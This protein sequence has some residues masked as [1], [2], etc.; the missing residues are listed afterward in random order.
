MP[1]LKFGSIYSL[2]DSGAS[3]Q[4]IKENSAEFRV[5]DPEPD[6]P[7][8]IG[9]DVY[10]QVNPAVAMDADGDFTVTWQSYVSS[11]S[12]VSDIYAK[13]FSAAALT[14]P[15]NVIISSHSVSVLEGGSST[16]SV[17][18]AYQPVSPLTVTISGGNSILSVDKTS[19]T[20]NSTNWNTPQT[21]T[22]T[23]AS[24]SNTTN[25]VAS[26]NVKLSNLVEQTVTA[27]QVDAQNVIVSSS[28]VSVPEGGTNT[29]TVSLAGAPTSNVT[30]NLTK[31]SGGDADLTLDTDP[32]TPGNQTTLTFTPTNWNTPQTVTVA[33]AEDSDV[34]NGTAT[35]TLS[36]TGYA[37]T[38]VTLTEVDNDH[39]YITVSNTY[40]FAGGGIHEHGH[41]RPWRPADVRCDLGDCEAGR[42][43][44]GHFRQ[45]IDAYIHDRQL[46][47]AA[48]RDV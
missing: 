2:T 15:N 1:L 9:L 4:T 30:V 10:D 20:F 31:N 37:S 46:E 24:D 35:Y 33:A 36:A 38:S 41:N 47:H 32:N 34:A 44:F 29:F 12:S 18:L 3:V 48:D 22:I 17:Q 13:R 6:D 27:T 5:N 16:F 28:A 21:V 14:S 45:Q 40:R 26:F 19:L 43:Q 11:T 23:S 25:D 8:T 42:Q 39:N 7:Y